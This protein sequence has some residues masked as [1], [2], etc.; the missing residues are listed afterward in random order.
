MY[1][2]EVFGGL[3]GEALGGRLSRQRLSVCNGQIVGQPRK[4]E[5][6]QNVRKMSENCPKI[7]RKLSGGAENTIFG[8]FLDKIFT[9]LVDALF[10]EPVQCSPVTTLG[11]VAPHRVAP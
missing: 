9:Y 10:A 8:H 4:R 11:P 1:L 5:C 3:L 6:R 7:V 2:S